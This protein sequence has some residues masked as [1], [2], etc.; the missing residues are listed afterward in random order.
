MSFRTR[1]AFALVRFAGSFAAF[2]SYVAF[3]ILPKKD[4]KRLE[5]AARGPR[6]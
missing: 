1:F 4:R 5:R 2:V 6:R 3:R